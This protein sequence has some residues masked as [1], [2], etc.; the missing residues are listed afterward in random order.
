MNTYLALDLGGTKL[1][2]A[3]VDEQGKLLNSKRYPSGYRNQTQAVTGILS[4]LDDYFETVGFVGKPQALGM[5]LTGKVDHKRGIWRSLSHIDQ[6]MIPLAE[7]LT[8]KTGLS[9]VI[10]NDMHAA[11]AAEL[12]LGWGKRCDDFIYLNVG[13]GLAA[14]FVADRHIIHGYNNMSGEIGHTSN[15][16]N[17]DHTCTICG[18]EGCCEQ[19][20]SGI[21]FDVQARRLISVYPGS[22]LHIPDDPH[23]KVSGAE[24]FALAEEGDALCTRIVDEGVE[25]LVVLISNMI[26]YTD[27]AA[28]ILGGGMAMNDTL[29][30][31]VKDGLRRYS[32]MNNIPFGVVRSTFSPGEVGII[33]AAALAMP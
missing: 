29:L 4:H 6:E 13:T 30:S 20:V 3:E 23:C 33:G 12:K 14:G 17:Y 15:G 9:A 18:K 2:I 19:T 24:I 22:K 8:D 25:A 26:R 1:M 27:P 10:D 31:R 32:A 11:A 5:G 7:I 21:G 16:I 28:V